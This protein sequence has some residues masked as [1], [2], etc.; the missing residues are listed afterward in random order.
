LTAVLLLH[1]QPG[2]ARD[3]HRVLAA[4]PRSLPSIAID[5][6]GWDRR[7]R[8]TGLEGNARAALAALDA[9]GA[10]RAVVVGH[11]F[12]G[13]VAT[14]LAVHHPD[15]VAALVLAAPSAN[16]AALNALDRALAAPVVGV[17]LGAAALAAPALTFAFAPARRSLAE[18]LGLDEDYLRRTGRA[19][20]ERSAWRAFSIEQ[21][22]LFED[23][24]VLER[25][26]A[27]IS[28]PTTIAIGSYDRIVSVASAQ[29]L[30]TQI[31][32]AALVV[33]EGAG[34]LAPLR[35]APRLAQLITA[36]TRRFP[37]DPVG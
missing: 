33:I 2:G 24:R 35:H 21:R 20:I 1:G 25:R 5:R 6:P 4:L 17:F 22:A 27:A 8:A 19:L 37:T 12:G 36:A 28:A 16:L 14:W 11:S 34:H 29:Q 30:A 9:R 31:P 3:W 10:S 15:R 23:L 13:A 32:D 26:L 18:R 7:S